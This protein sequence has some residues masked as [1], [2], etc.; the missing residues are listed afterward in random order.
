MSQKPITR[1]APS[2]TGYLHIGGARTALFNWA[3]ARRFGGKFLLRI[4]DTDRERST[5][6][7]EAAVIDGLQWLG[8]NWDA[9]PVRQSEREARYNEIIDQLLTTGKAYRCICTKEELEERKQAVIATG[10]KWRYD[11]RCREAELGNDC[12]SHVIRMRMPESGKLGWQDGVFGESG[13]D[14]RELGDTILRRSDGVPIYHLAVVVDD[15]DMGINHVIRGADH[16]N[17]TPLQLAIYAALDATPPAYSHVPLIVGEGGKKLSKRQDA[18][19]VQSYQAA[20]FLPET[21]CN[22]LIRLGWSHGD[23]EV[24]SREE[25]VELFDLDTVH[26]SPA[27]VDP[28]K[29][30]WLNQHYIKTLPAETLL[31]PLQGFLPANVNTDSTDMT[32]LAKGIELL[33]DRSKTLMEMAEGA[34]FLLHDQIEYQEKAAK[35]FLNAETAPRLKALQKG[36]GELADWNHAGI[37]QV[38]EQVQASLDGIGMGKLAQPIR[39]ALTGGTVSPGIFETLEVLGQSCSLERLQRAIDSITVEEVN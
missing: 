16:L 33:R 32:R 31:Q 23:Q 27:Q 8:L 34:A 26:R 19:S 12:G 39:V 28:Q 11:G 22:W 10:A 20:G 37:Q 14:A 7:S 9:E 21:L 4:E 38:F 36:L 17:N 1:F 13:Q 35:K 2:P 24:F 5:Q 25:I 29:L 6:E 3:Y 30:R 18:V 15:L